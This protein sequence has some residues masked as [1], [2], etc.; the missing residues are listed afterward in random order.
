MAKKKK[1]KVFADL[2]Q[3]IDLD[4]FRISVRGAFSDFPDP[5]VATRCVYPAWFMFLAILSGYLAGCNTIADIVH[6]VEL[7]EAWFANLAGLEIQA[8]SYNTLW[9]FLTRVHPTAFKALIAKWFQQLDKELKDQ[10]L[11]IDGK[12]LRGIS[13]SEHVSHIVELFAAES[14]LIIA[15]EKVPDKASERKAL[16]SLLDSVDVKGAIVTIDAL[17]AHITDV[18]AVLQRGADYI[19]GI[20][21]NQGILEAEAHN[22]FEQAYSVDYED[23]A[24][25]RTAGVEKGHGRIEERTVCVTNDLDWLPQKEQWNLQSLIEVRSQR[26]ISGKTEKSIRYYGSSRQGTA[27]Q[28]ALWIREHWGIESMH[29]VMDVVFEEDASLGDSG[30]SA[31]NMSLIRRLAGN[32]IHMYDPGRGVASARR[33][34]AYEPNYL[35]GLLG[36]VFVK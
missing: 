13:D 24:V 16:P 30:S 7:R 26:I 1:D 4:K 31:E 32:I 11:V 10:L 18:K 17:Y 25:T 21:G 23:V 34:A 33:C 9:W 2:T 20:K 36:K 3:D 5:R 14:R 29:Y 15:Q 8:P 35:R 6:F 12:R 19:V 28:F 27:D 22:F